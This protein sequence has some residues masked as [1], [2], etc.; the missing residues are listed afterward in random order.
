MEIE[1]SLKCWQAVPRGWIFVTCV[2]LEKCIVLKELRKLPSLHNHHIHQP[3]CFSGISCF[4]HQNRT[5]GN[6]FA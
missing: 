2:R 6:G 1:G 5:L 4:H 3:L